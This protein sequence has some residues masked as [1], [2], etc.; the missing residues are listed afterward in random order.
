[1][2]KCEI[3]WEK[4]KKKLCIKINNLKNKGYI[5]PVNTSNGDLFTQNIFINSCIFIADLICIIIT[6]YGM[7]QQL[8]TYFGVITYSIYTMV[9]QF[10][11]IYSQ[12]LIKKGKIG[13]YRI[14][15]FKHEFDYAP[16]IINLIVIIIVFCILIFSSVNYITGGTMG[17]PTYV[18]LIIISLFL[19]FIIKVK[20]MIYD[21]FG[22]FN[23]KFIEE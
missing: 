17:K 4:I 18:L 21:S 9:D 1:M 8:P 14:K 3:F 22:I 10:K 6:L 12:K 20:Y 19:L 11:I 7:K 2:N 5:I 15:N 23:W 13:F 16:N